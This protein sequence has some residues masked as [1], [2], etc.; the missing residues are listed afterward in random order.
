[1]W[2]TRWSEV[3]NQVWSDRE[4]MIYWMYLSRTTRYTENGRKC[5]HKE[6]GISESMRMYEVVHHTWSECCS[7]GYRRDIVRHQVSVWL[8]DRPGAK[9]HV[10][11][12]IRLPLVQSVWSLIIHRLPQDVKK[13]DCPWYIAAF[14]LL[15]RTDLT[16]SRLVFRLHHG[17]TEPC[18]VSWMTPFAQE[19]R[20]LTDCFT[21]V[22]VK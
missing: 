10:S 17:H 11:R 21:T 5:Q 2:R 14:N 13:S 15:M 12:L 8:G 22:M 7:V 20:T 18:R 6:N 1:M 4:R 16:L 3:G 19:K 9:T